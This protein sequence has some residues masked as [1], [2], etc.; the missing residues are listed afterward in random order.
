MLTGSAGRDALV[1]AALDLDELRSYRQRLV[2]EE[3]IVSYWR[4][5][6]QARLDLLHLACDEQEHVAVADIIQALDEPAGTGRRPALLSVLTEEPLPII[7]EIGDVWMQPLRPRDAEHAAE[8]RRDSA[9]AETRLSARRQDLF[10][11]L[12]AATAEL[13]RRYACD[14]A[15]AL[16][17]LPD[18]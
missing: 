4:R 11:R 3:V 1:L 9:E 10:T 16:T 18:G 8:V 14:P 6:V 13:V 7:P 2:D 5:V 17:L 15:A 12:D